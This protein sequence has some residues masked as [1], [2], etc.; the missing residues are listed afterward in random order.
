MSTTARLLAFAPDLDLES[1]IES[2]ATLAAV[3]R[4]ET[5]DGRPDLGALGRRFGWLSAPRTTVIQPGP[6]HSGL[7]RDP[8][9]TLD[10]LL[11]R[12]VR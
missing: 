4:G 5:G 1:V 8:A 10:D 3:C 11:T 6:V 9:A 2:L 12:L 7:T